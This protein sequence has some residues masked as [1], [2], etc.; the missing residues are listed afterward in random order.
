MN[1]QFNFRFS[2]LLILLVATLVTACK[3][4]DNVVPSPDLGA[5]V[6][7]TYTYS[8]L[9]TGGKT[10]PASDTNLKGTIKLT[11][12]TAT[13]VAIQLAIVHKATN[14]TFA[15][16]AAEDVEVVE[17]GIGNIELHYNGDTI[18]KIKGTKISIEGEDDAGT[19][20][21]LFATK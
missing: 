2:A 7:G 15:D 19:L 14:E 11:R 17:S 16:D 20:F 5:Q 8:E 6:A 21:T 9:K 4:G 10:Y 13:T 12:Q 1:S 18:A 3:K